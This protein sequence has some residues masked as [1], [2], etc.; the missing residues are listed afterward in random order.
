VKLRGNRI[1]LAEIEAALARV[2]GVREAAVVLRGETSDT[3]RLVAY[4]V[5]SDPKVPP[6]AGWRRELARW[7]PAVMLPSAL[8]WLPSLPL[9][10]NGKLDRRG[11][12]ALTTEPA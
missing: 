2:P 1:E 3:R 8:V 10:A 6:P 5:P 11:I 4:A 7:L 9:N 12:A